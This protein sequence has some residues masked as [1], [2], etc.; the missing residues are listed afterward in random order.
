M[1][2]RNANMFVK[3]WIFQDFQKNTEMTLDEMLTAFNS[4]GNKLEQHGQQLS[5]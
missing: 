4:L 2:G 5:S 1:V 3:Q